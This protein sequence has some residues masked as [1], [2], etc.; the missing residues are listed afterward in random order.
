[1]LSKNEWRGD[2]T[3]ICMCVFSMYI[4]LGISIYVFYMYI[5][6]CLGYSDYTIHT[7]VLLNMLRRLTISSNQ[8]GYW[9]HKQQ[10]FFI[11]NESTYYHTIVSTAWL[12]FELWIIS[13]LVPVN[14]NFID[15][16][17]L[18]TNFHCHKI[19]FTNILER[20]WRFNLIGNIF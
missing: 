16:M 3:Y 15:L 2:F 4:V 19:T 12:N 7:Y 20:T 18:L 13:K 17:I 8:I 11:I 1:M 6:I 10:S 5:W 9:P 14:Q